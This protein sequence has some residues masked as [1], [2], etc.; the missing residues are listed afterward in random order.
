MALA[1]VFGIETEYGITVRGDERLNPVVASTLVVSSYKDLLDRSVEWD[2]D[3]E[4]PEQDARG[5]A[6]PADKAPTVE[7]TLTNVV[8]PNGARLY[9]DHAHPEYSTPE[10]SDPIE[11]VA[12]DAAGVLVMRKA[13]ARLESTLGEGQSVLLYKNNTDGKG[14]SYGCHE[15][16][17]VSREVSFDELAAKLVPYFVSRQVFCGAGKVGAENG[18]E[19]VNFQISQRADFFEELVGLETTIRRPIINTRDEPHADPALF[20]RLHVIIGDASMSQYVTFLKIGATA[21]VLQM[22]EDGFIE[23]DLTLADPIRALRA[24]SRDLTC[25]T[26]LER[27]DGTTVTPVELQWNYYELA[28]KW[29]EGHEHSPWTESVLA[30]WR[31]V[32]EGLESD[33][34]SMA[35]RLDWVAKHQVIEAYRSSRG[36]DWGDPKLAMIDLQYHD[37]RSDRGLYW[38]L[39]GSGGM[40]KLVD[41]DAISAAES[42]PPETTRAYFRG[43][44]IEHFGSSIVSAN[45]DS[46]V[47]DTGKSSLQRIPMMNPHKGSKVAVGHLFEKAADPQE[48]IE[49]LSS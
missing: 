9:V 8:L 14:N 3:D 34:S 40:V 22:I 21:I 4:H 48:L 19:P 15:N 31:E 10:C 26:P 6:V 30:A 35:D 38:K 46:V 1:K 13:V 41:D 29:R 7:P 36:L 18:T 24:T 33:P 20:R 27:A 45:W 2:F 49:L 16:Y 42:S 39:E 32:L 43:R 11:L 12:H 47:V 28:E 5:F 17:L 25:R 23:K 44:A 37:I